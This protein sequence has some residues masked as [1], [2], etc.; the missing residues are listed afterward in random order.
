MITKNK[1]IQQQ[2]WLHVLHA[3]AHDWLPRESSFSLLEKIADPTQ[4]IQKQPSNERTICLL[5]QLLS[6]HTHSFIVQ[7]RGER[8]NCWKTFW[9]SKGGGRQVERKQIKNKTV[10]RKGGKLATTATALTMGGRLLSPKLWRKKISN[11]SCYRFSYTRLKTLI[12]KQIKHK[13]LHVLYFLC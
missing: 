3:V 7:C 1:E 2:N 8:R 4:L 9:K 11:C 5:F 13:T 6:T 10:Q 12:Q